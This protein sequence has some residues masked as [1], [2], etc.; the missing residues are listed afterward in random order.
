MFECI[1]VQ[2]KALLRR[3]QQGHSSKGEH[4]PRSACHRAAEGAT[5]A[6][7]NSWA[8]ILRLGFLLSVPI[9]AVC[10]NNDIN[11]LSLTKVLV[12][13]FSLSE[14][15][16]WLS[17]GGPVGV[18]RSWGRLHCPL[19]WGL[20][21]S[22]CRGFQ[23]SLWGSQEEELWDW[24]SET[25]K[26]GQRILPWRWIL[27]Q[28]PESSASWAPGSCPGVNWWEYLTLRGFVD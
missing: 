6:P 15:L 3:T 9:N 7:D 21:P 24:V 8:Q 17:W 23:K 27:G 4:Q 22:P 1:S 18:C 19:L 13:P 14:W 11:D 28:V 5:A 10:N 25:R 2:S 26:G 12:I 20:E 16:C